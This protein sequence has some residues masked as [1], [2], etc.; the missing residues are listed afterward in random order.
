MDI[1]CP[2]EAMYSVNTNIKGSITGFLTKVT[3][4]IAFTY[5]IQLKI[6]KI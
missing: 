1:Q 5:I 2:Q 6:V 3:K 4:K